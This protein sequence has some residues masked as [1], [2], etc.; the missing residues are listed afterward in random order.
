MRAMGYRKRECE[1]SLD[2]ISPKEYFERRLN[3]EKCK[4]LMEEY[5]WGGK[6]PKIYLNCEFICDVVSLFNSSQYNKDDLMLKCLK[7]NMVQVG[8]RGKICIQFLELVLLCMGI[9]IIYLC[10]DIYTKKQNR[11][12]VSGFQEYIKS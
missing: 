2:S 10:I 1:S 12:I 7:Y 3:K 4:T 8:V 11:D 9:Y 6:F 5:D